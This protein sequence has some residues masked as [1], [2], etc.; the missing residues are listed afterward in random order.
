MNK[1]YRLQGK[2]TERKGGDILGKDRQEKNLKKAAESN[3][4]VTNH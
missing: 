1:K 3:L 2:I 4:T